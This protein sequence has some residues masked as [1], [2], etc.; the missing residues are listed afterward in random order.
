[1]CGR[2]L[3]IDTPPS[4][5][6]W[7]EGEGRRKTRLVYKIKAWWINTSI[8]CDENTMEHGV[9]ADFSFNYE[10]LLII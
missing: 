9:G 6:G 2:T 7:R 5:G 1:V 8:N 10:N 4:E 3:D